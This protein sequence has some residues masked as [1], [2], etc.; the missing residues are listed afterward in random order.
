MNCLEWEREI[1]IESES[2]ELGEN[3]FFWKESTF[4]RPIAAGAHGR[5][6]VRRE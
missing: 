5:E 3:V 4:A 2:A 1:A 6:G